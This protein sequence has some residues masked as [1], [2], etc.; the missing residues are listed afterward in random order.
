MPL[1][2]PRGHGAAALAVEKQGERQQTLSVEGKWARV[3][4][5][6]GLLSKHRAVPQPPCLRETSPGFPVRA[7][8]S[9]QE[10]GEHSSQGNA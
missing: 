6:Q 3:G 7:W 8:L 4:G 9:R 1:G 2:Y 10:A 5:M